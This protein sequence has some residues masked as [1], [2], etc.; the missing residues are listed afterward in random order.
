MS[1][2]IFFFIPSSLWPDELPKDVAQNWAGFG[3]GLYA[4]TLQTCLRLQAAGLACELTQQVPESGIVFCHSNVLRR[5]TIPPASRR[6]LVCIKAEAPRCA[7]APLHIVQNPLEA[8]AG[9]YF[10]PHWPQPQLI[11]RDRRRGDRFETLAFFGHAHSLAPE[12]TTPAW[13]AALAARGL[14]MHYIA[15]TNRWNNYQSIDTRWNDYHAIDAVIA[16]R[17]FNKWHQRLSSSFIS[18]PATK[19]YNAW[20]SGTIPILGKESA[21]RAAGEPGENYIEVETMESLLSWLDR[22]KADIDLRR[23]LIA[24]GQQQAQQ[25]TPENIVLQWKNFLSQVALPAYEKWLSYSP[26]RQQQILLAA[27]AA[28]YRDRLWRRGREQLLKVIA[29]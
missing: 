7:L 5:M 20:L 24:S 23:S 22:L 14:R 17:T 26:A 6:L 19:L 29:P 16:V 13:E 11:A 4:W 8:S 28:S 10:M 15:N 21:Y 3:L 25:Y 9:C 1:P 2:N 12:L 18:K 27:R